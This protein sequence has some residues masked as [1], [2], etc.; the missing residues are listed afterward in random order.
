VLEGSA[1]SLF[2]DTTMQRHHDTTTPRHHDTAV[3][4]DADL[5]RDLLTAVGGKDSMRLSDGQVFERSCWMRSS[6]QWCSA[7]QCQKWR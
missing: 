5:G 1:G 7:A 3:K 2:H 6:T 4:R